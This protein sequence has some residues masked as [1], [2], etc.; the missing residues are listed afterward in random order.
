VRF[1]VFAPSAPEPK[2]PPPSSDTEWD[3]VRRELYGENEGRAVELAMAGS[4]SQFDRAQVDEL[5]KVLLQTLKNASNIHNLKPDDSI[6]ITVFGQPSASYK[7]T[8][9]KSQTTN[10]F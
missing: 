3:K 8:R 5:E 4:G 9:S 2:E 1:P 10:F 6:A 7:R